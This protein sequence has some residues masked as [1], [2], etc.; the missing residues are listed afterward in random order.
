MTKSNSLILESK[1]KLKSN[2]RLLTTRSCSLLLWKSAV[3][4][5]SYLAA[6][7]MM[8]FV[9][10]TQNLYLYLTLLYLKMKYFHSLKLE[11]ENII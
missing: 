4:V 5:I 7:V 2:F 9:S 8:M 10:L 3:D 11:V 6:M 1:H